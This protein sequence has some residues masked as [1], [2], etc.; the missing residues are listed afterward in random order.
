MMAI[1]EVVGTIGCILTILIV[2]GAFIVG[3]YIIL[4]DSFNSEF[5]A[6]TRVSEIGIKESQESKSLRERIKNYPLKTLSQK[7]FEKIPA[8]EDLE[9]G[10]LE[11]CPI[12]TWF[13]CK[14]SEL[15]P[16]I[17][18]IGQVVKGMDAFCDQVGASLLSLRYREIN[19]YRVEITASS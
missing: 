5:S 17:I 10:F 8:A 9:E 11:T 4:K 14:R 19:H 2:G 15:C 16:E 12:G 1:S 3:L 6:E 18:V 7:E 13:R